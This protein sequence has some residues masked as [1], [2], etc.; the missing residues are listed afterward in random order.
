MMLGDV[1]VVGLDVS[2]TVLYDIGMDVPHRAV[3]T[4]P[5]D[6]ATVSKDLWRALNQRRLFQLH[7]GP[8][9]PSPVRP[10]VP[11]TAS[12]EAWQSKCHQLEAENLKLKEKVDRLE[13]LTTQASQPLAAPPAVSDERLDEILRLLKEG[14]VTPAGVASVSPVAK[15]AKAAVVVDVE[16]PAFIPNEIKP[17]S[18]EGRIA[19]VQAETSDKANLGTAASTLR[20]LRKGQT[21]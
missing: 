17:K 19:E 10:T 6:R 18:V 16:V 7:A 8:T 15:T 9:G 14:A 21:Q 12:I 1:T 5:A 20:K 4:I 3:V 11:L 2:T 13:A